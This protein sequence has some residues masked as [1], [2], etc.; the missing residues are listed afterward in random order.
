MLII[1][2]NFFPAKGKYISQSMTLHNLFIMMQF[3]API[4]E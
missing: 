2:S 3:L 1:G 4:Y